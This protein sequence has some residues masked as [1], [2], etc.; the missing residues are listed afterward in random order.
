M[1]MIVI[2]GAGYLGWYWYVTHKNQAPAITQPQNTANQNAIPQNALFS[3]NFDNQ[4][5]LNKW[6]IYDDDDSQDGPSHWFF[7]DGV[8][9]Q[10]ANIWGGT[11]GLPVSNK[12]YLGSRI[13]TKEGTDW[14]NIF[15]KFKFKPLDNDGLG[16]LV[17]YQDKDN[18]LRV[19]TIQD[20]TQDN[21]GPMIKIDRRFH[22][23]TSG[24]FVKR[25]TY[26]TGEWNEGNLVVKGNKI[27]FWLDNDKKKSLIWAT[28]NLLKKGR[29]G[30]SVYAEEGVEFD[31]VVIKKL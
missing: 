10:D 25:F 2:S 1:A 24:L 16:F 29:F 26:K 15:A 31:E 12:S 27:T 13:V 28:D 21:G 9:K 5:D 7:A 14:K 6:E 22:G 11:F 18:Y 17:R 3:S 20:S 30:F 4:S 19:F 8:L 23:V